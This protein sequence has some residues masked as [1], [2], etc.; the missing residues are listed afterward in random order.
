MRN[1]ELLPL[2]VI[3]FGGIVQS[4][5]GPAKQFYRM[6]MDVVRKWV[7]GDFLHFGILSHTK[8]KVPNELISPIYFFSD[9]VTLGTL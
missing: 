2:Y 3:L 8:K 4:A 5:H 6:Y 9:G 1:D 7:I